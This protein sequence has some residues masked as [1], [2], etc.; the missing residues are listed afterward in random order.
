MSHPLPRTL[1]AAIPMLM[2]MVSA[3][4]AA[5]VEAGK[6]VFKR[7]QIC[8]RIEAGAPAS[9]GPNLHGLFGRKAGSL[10]GYDYSE[11]MKNSGVVWDD[12]T[13]RKYLGDPKSFIPGNKMAFPGLKNETELDNLLAYLKQAT[14]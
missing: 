13:L 10:E 5:D 14:Q 2:S 4:A 9:L 12:D 6:A 11:A 1:F 8:H 3:W 7:C